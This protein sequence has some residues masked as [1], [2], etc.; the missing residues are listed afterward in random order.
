V[1]DLDWAGMDK[2]RFGDAQFVSNRLP[3]SV[4]DR[5]HEES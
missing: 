1:Y 3:R 4:I 5:F 2:L